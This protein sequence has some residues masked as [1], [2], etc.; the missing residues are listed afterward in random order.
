MK[1]ILVI[2]IA[3]SFSLLAQSENK[4]Q[5]IE[6]PAF[7]ITGVQSVSLPTLNKNKSEFVPVIGKEFLTP[8]YDNEEF[9]LI[10]NTNPIKK[11]MEL[12]SNVESYNGLLQLGAGLQTLPIGRLDF[13]FNKNNFLFNTHIFGSDIRDFLPYAGYNTSG[14]EVSLSYYLNHKLN[15]FP[16]MTIN[17][18]GGFVRD[19][20][21]FYGSDI[22]TFERENE[23]YYG[24]IDFLNR[25]N[26]DFLYGATF[27][28]NYLNMKMENVKENLSKVNGFLEYS[29]SVVSVGANGFYKIQQVNVGELEYSKYNYFS[30]DAYLH[31]NNSDI[32]NLKIG[33]HY[34]QQD[35]NN[36]FSPTAV[37]S[38][39]VE[40]GVALFLSYK[41]NSKLF[42]IQD[43][44]YE[45][46]YFETNRKNIFQKNYSKLN[47]SIK[48]DFSDI[49]EINAG[50]Y[51]SKYDNYHYYEDLA[52]DNR[53]TLVPINDV[54]ET[55]AFFNILVNTKS[56]G[57]LFA[58]FEF[59]DVKDKEG[60]KIPY[61]PLLNGSLSYGYFL[62]FGLYSKIKVSYSSKIYTDL[63]NRNRLPNYV[64]LSLLLKYNIFETLALTCNLQN[65]LNRKEYLL[66]GYQE[67]PLDII[68]GIEYRW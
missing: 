22:P 49:F 24:N 26:K 36:I 10:D 50:F 43:I 11:Q 15:I 2:L 57:E 68:V 65:I 3:L 17:L 4:N 18:R 66:K 30:G 55:G 13:S 5:S 28:G 31:F 25:L 12:Y 46:R 48:Y 44:L 42:T 8:K 64:N 37:L 45:N 53:F 20:Y 32:F 63:L 29:L 58:D 59:Q 33:V 21:N 56:Y 62:N 23:K 34:S 16:G 39:F 60:Y 67:K 19:Q 14:A 27:S 61:K 40:E 7:V 51:S 9:A 1:K 41:G 54:K 35:T 6:L 52:K 38:I 47:L